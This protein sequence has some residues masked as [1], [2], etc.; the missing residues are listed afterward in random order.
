MMREKEGPGEGGG[1]DE[2]GQ[3]DRTGFL[4][5]RTIRPFRLAEQ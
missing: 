5:M 1:G 4:I 2:G 3:G